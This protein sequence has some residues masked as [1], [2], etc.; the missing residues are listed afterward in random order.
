MLVPRWLW[1]APAVRV[2]LEGHPAMGHGFL[3]SLPAHVPC[4]PQACL[5]LH[6]KKACLTR[7]AELEGAAAG[8]G[9]E[10]GDV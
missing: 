6:W 7:R 4:C 1:L 5:N 10:A 2:F 3:L 9:Q 8:G